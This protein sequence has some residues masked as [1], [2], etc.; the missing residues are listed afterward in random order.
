M[1]NLAATAEGERSILVIN[2]GNQSEILLWLD[3]F[4]GV[5]SMNLKV[6]PA[7]ENALATAEEGAGALS[8]MFLVFGSFTIGAGLLL[9]LTIV[10]MLA[11][12]RRI[13]EAILRAIGLKRSDMRSLAVME[14]MFTSAAASVLGGFFGLILAWIVSVAFSSVFANAG[15]DG[16]AYS[17]HLKCTYWN[18]N[19]LHHCDV[20][21]VGYGFVDKSSKHCPSL[22][23]PFTSEKKGCS[24]VVG[25][26]YDWICWRWCFIRY[27]NFHFRLLFVAKVCIVECNGFLL[28]SR[29]Y[30]NFHIHYSTCFRKN[31]SKY[32]S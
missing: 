3:S 15:A 31:N 22:T 25:S 32:W 27:L 21:L 7:K 6:V 23:Q 9:V 24:M 20:N 11:E 30:P 8:A 10:M 4:A 14:G 18:V 12:S 2:D 16:I 26:S 28:D 13:D 5:D 19:R 17:L 1:E 29:N